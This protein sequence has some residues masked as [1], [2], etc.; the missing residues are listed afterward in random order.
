MLF[1]KGSVEN[2]VLSSIFYEFGKTAFY[3]CPH[4]PDLRN[5]DTKMYLRNRVD[6]CLE[7]FPNFNLTDPNSP[8][9]RHKVTIGVDSNYTPLGYIRRAARNGFAHAMRMY[10]DKGAGRKIG[11]K[12]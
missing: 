9:F 6:Q 5:A 4:P 3:E 7:L 12:P 11:Q 8:L 1:L 2:R 10:N